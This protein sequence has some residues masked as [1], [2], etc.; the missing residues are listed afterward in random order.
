MEISSH[1]SHISFKIF[2]LYLFWGLFIQ[3]RGC[4]TEQMFNILRRRRGVGGGRGQK[5]SGRHDKWGSTAQLSLRLERQNRGFFGRRWDSGIDMSR[6]QLLSQRGAFPQHN[7]VEYFLKLLA[8]GS[9]SQ[10][11]R[12]H[13]VRRNDWRN[14]SSA[15]RHLT[16]PVVQ[17]WQLVPDVTTHLGRILQG[18]TWMQ[19]CGDPPL[20]TCVNVIN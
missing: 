12:S 9:Q 20:S 17:I 19:V 4:F 18:S 13:R 7:R 6:Y 5:Y 3:P 15:V 10:L 16:T 11:T 8:G 1:L 2:L 14:T